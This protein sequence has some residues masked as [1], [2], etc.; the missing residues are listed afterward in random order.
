MGNQTSQWFELYYMDGLDRLVKEKLRMPHYT[1]F[2][3]LAEEARAKN[4]YAVFAL[5]INTI[6]GVSAQ[7]VG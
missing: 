3:S 2:R 5:C 4:S 1:P 7:I 6:C